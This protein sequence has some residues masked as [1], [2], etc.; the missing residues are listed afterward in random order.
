V[1][2]V[3]A[4]AI[5][6]SSGVASA[7]R[8]PATRFKAHLTGDE[9][10]PSVDTNA[11]GQANFKLSK[12]G[13]ELSYKLNVANIEDVIGAHVHQAPAGQNGG[14]V[15]YLFGAPFVADTDAVTVNGTLAEGTITDADVVGTSPTAETLAELL[16][17]MRAGNTYV[18]VHTLANR[19]GEVRGQIS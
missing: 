9:E 8:P 12:D 15:A 13:S 5:V 1:K 6:A 17:V 14:I 7:A 19:P 3:G 10:V 18:N 2:A 16:D 4:G 11:Q